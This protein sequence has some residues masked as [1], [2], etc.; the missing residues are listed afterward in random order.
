MSAGPEERLKVRVKK[1]ILDRWPE[2]VVVKYHGSRYSEAGVSDLLVCVDGQF[3]ALELK[4]P[5][6]KPR[7]D[8]S[9]ALQKVFGMRVTNAGGVFAFVDSVEAALETIDL[10]I[11]RQFY[12][13][14][15]NGLTMKVL[16]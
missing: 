6:A 13:V 4:A 14:P 2:A 3:V 16:D 15:V 7:G 10:A 1:A 11:K 8:S 12:R 5:G 9:E